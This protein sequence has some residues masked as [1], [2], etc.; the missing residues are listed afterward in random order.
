MLDATK[1]SI[2]ALADYPGYDPMRFEAFPRE[3][4][5]SAAV[6]DQFEPGSSFKLVVCAAA[7]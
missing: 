5:K 4:Y 6:S 7:S 3:S 1:G 2:L